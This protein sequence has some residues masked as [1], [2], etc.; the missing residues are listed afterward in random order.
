MIC[1]TNSPLAHKHNHT[2][3]HT[4]LNNNVWLY[5]CV[6]FLLPISCHFRSRFNYSF[7]A[8]CACVSLFNVLFF[9]FELIYFLGIICLLF[10]TLKNKGKTFSTIV[11]FCH[12]G[13]YYVIKAFPFMELTV[14]ITITITTTWIPFNH[15]RHHDEII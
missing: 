1:W 7:S 11:V 9:F 5:V 4:S 13:I 6:P 10:L 8:M 14:T 3:S 12:N 2:H 15:H